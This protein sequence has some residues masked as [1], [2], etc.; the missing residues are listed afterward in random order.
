M[1][2]T[3]KLILT[4][5]LLLVFA[6]CSAQSAPEDTANQTTNETKGVEETNLKDK[7]IAIIYFT[8]AENVVVAEGMDTTTAAST[9]M[10]NDKMV[11]NVGY[12]A[13]IIQEQVG[14]DLYPI[15][16]VDLYQTEYEDQTAKEE[17]NVD[18][19]PEITTTISNLDEYDVVFLGY[20]NWWY[21]FPMAMYTFLESNDLSN[22]TIIPFVTHGGSEFSNTLETLKEMYP[23]ANI[24]DGLEVFQ[25]DV[26]ASEPTIISWL[27]EIGF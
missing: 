7:N 16:K 9:V 21:D 15:K 25:H 4:C 18:A 1:K 22:K 20:P 10:R 6:G 8:R 24:L 17:G 2:N 26:E 23:S 19:R 11:G 3:I 12:V 14:G 13:E 27:N 5:S